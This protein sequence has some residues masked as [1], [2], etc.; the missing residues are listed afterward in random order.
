MTTSTGISFERW[1]EQSWPAGA[2]FA[3]GC[4][5]AGAVYSRC[6]AEGEPAHISNE[7]WETLNEAVAQLVAH[8]CGDGRSAWVFEMALLWI[9]RREDGSWAGVFAATPMSEATRS[10][11]EARLDEF[12]GKAP[13]PA[14]LPEPV[15][16]A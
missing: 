12:L 8:E 3:G 5:S 1:L 2:V 7:A 15:P 10:G 4:D 16:T 9:A 11:I 14:P 6:V 13:R